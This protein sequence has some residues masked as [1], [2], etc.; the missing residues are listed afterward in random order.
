MG[1]REEVVAA[2]R[3]QVGLPY[4]THRDCSGFTAWCYAQAGI[5]IPQGSEAQRREG[6]RVG[7]GKYLPGD[8]L[9]WA[10]PSGHVA[11][12]EDNEQVIHALNERAGIVRS[13]I[14]AEMGGAFQGARRIIKGES[15]PAET[16]TFGNVKHPPYETH[17]VPKP[18][19]G[20]GFDR[21]PPR[22]VVGVCDH[23]WWGYGDALALVRLFGTG[24]ERQG[25]ALTDYSITQE[26]E[27]VLLNEWW[28]TRSP[29]ANGPANDLEGDGPLFVRKL[30]VGAV[31]ARLVSIENEGKDDRLTDIQFR[32]TAEL[33]AYLFDSCRVPYDQYPY[34]PNV[35][36]VTSLQHWEL[37]PKQCPFAGMRSQTDALQDAVRG[38]LKAAQTGGTDEPIPPVDPPEP[39]HDWL[40]D[41]MTIDIVR[42][43]FG[44]GVRHNADGTETEVVFDEKGVIS[45]AWLARGAKDKAYPGFQEWWVTKDSATGKNRHVV[46][47]N[48]GW[49]LFGDGADRSSW[50][51]L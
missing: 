3:S 25:D 21:V 24:G 22:K 50:K 19:E 8:L 32:R 14:Y 9:F 15:K 13:S 2:A 38:I 48:N 51:W 11:L 29:W 44:K 10:T 33:H 45:N 31:N 28:G 41:G 26:G 16:I 7:E 37:G 1:D 30:G 4:A 36:C 40:P 47:F 12:Y 43:L 17:I 35:G 6:E 23:K 49:V 46:A 39:D 18:W 27:V 34:N 42:A 5:T 20:A